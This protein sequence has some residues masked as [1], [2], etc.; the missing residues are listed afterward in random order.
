M[1]KKIPSPRAV[2]FKISYADKTGIE[3]TERLLLGQDIAHA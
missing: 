1:F 2:S 3:A